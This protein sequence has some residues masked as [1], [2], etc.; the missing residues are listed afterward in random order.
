MCVFF[1]LLRVL[2]KSADIPAGDAAIVPLLLEGVDGAI[3]AV[4]PHEEGLAVAKV[5][6]GFE[7]AA[8]IA[9]EYLMILAA[10]NQIVDFFATGNRKFQVNK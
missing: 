8:A 3:L 4:C 7:G 10:A 1:L 6:D 2:Y 9:A 5:K